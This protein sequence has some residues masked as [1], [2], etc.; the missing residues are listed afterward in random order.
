MTHDNDYVLCECDL[1]P[2]Q[3]LV[4]KLETQHAITIIKEPAVCLTM[5]KAEDSLDRQEFYLG[6]ALT[7]ECEVA[8]DG[9]IGYGVCLGDEPVRGYCLAVVDALTH[10]NSGLTSEVAAFI[11]EQRQLIADREIEEFNHILSTHVE[12]KLMEQE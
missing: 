3:E 2:L 7:T 1:P 12:F 6:E 9:S 11:D 5:I 8:I 10:S 4:T